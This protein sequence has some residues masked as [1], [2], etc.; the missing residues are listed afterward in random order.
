MAIARLSSKNGALFAALAG[1]RG[2]S[3]TAAPGIASGTSPKA[4]PAAKK[5]KSKAGSSDSTR[6]GK[7]NAKGRRV[8][9]IWCASEAEAVR[10]EQLKLIEAAGELIDLEPQPSYPCVIN[11]V[12][13]CVYRADFRYK[14]R[15]LKTGHIGPE[16][17]ED[18][19]GMQTETFI[20][21]RKLVEALFK[22]KLRLIPAKDVKRWHG[23][24]E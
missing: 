9:G 18:V 6:K 16:V 10:F 5:S 23:R 22:V 19:K 11:G 14:P 13:V 17:I 2:V 4:K 1:R 8:H 15:C 12:K 24:T 21:K 20:L 3:I 7:Y